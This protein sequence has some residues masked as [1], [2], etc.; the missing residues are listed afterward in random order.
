MRVWLVSLGIL[1][2]VL[3]TTLG[4]SL[5]GGFYEYFMIANCDTVDR[6]RIV[7]SGWQIVPNQRDGCYFMRAR[8][9]LR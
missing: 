3:G 6:E 2:G 5:A 8:L 7:N 9:R 4:L 1:I